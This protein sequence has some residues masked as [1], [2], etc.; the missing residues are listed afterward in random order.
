MNIPDHFSDSLETV[1]RAKNTYIL[2]CGSGSRIRNLFDPAWKNLDPES[3]INI[4]DPENW[5]C[6]SVL[7]WYRSVSADSYR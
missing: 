3:G 1:F 4:P 5:C 6:G 7:F 2:G